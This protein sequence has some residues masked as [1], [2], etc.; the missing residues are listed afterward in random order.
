[1]AYKTA[2]ITERAERQAVDALECIEG[3][4]WRVIA[5]LATARTS[6]RISAEAFRTASSGIIAKAL[7][8]V[9][10]DGPDRG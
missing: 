9:E 5:E 8:R 3:P 4:Q 7:R 2:S 1:M 10:T 6:G